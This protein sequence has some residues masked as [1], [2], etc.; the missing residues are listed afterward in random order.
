MVYCFLK[1]NILTS[2]L[3]TNCVNNERFK[4]QIYHHFSTMAAVLKHWREAAT[5]LVVAKTSKLI[6][7]GVNGGGLQLAGTGSEQSQ[8]NYKMLMLKRSTKSKFMPNVYVFPG[9]IAEDADFSAEWLDLYKK[10]GESESKELLKYLT[11]AGTGPPMFSRTRDQEFQHIP[12]ELAFRICAIRETFEES[13]VLIARSIE[14]KSHLNSDYPR[15]PVWGTSVPMET[16]VSDEWRRRVDKNPLEFIKMCR[17]L[18]V[19]PDVWSLSEW[20]NWLTPVTLSSTGKGARR[21]YDTAF[22]M[23]VVDHL[24]EAMHDNNET[25]HLKWIAPDTLLS[26]YSHSKGLLAPPQVYEVHR[27][28]HFQLVE[29]LHRFNWDRALKHRVRQYFPVVVGCEDGIVVVYPG[30]ELYPEELDRNGESPTLTVKCSLEDLPKRYPSMNRMVVAGHHWV[31]TSAGDGQ[32][33]PDF[34]RTFPESLQP[35]L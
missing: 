16:Q 26:E 24:P 10:F 15:K 3:Y 5:L 1:R 25:V 30:D 28:L 34:E 33:I 18:N 27:L 8:Y 4:I 13:G 23:C 31:N 9:G 7:N 20:T 32:V 19:I 12:S 2:I 22:F 21:R 35:K 17:T 11:S 29:D 6:P 14:D